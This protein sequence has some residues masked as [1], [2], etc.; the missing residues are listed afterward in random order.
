MSMTVESDSCYFYLVFKVPCNVLTNR[1][2]CHWIDKHSWGESCV[3]FPVACKR[4]ELRVKETSSCLPWVC[5]HLLVD[6]NLVT[7]KRIYFISRVNEKEA[8]KHCG[9]LIGQNEFLASELDIHKMEISRQE[10]LIN[11]QQREITDL[12]EKLENSLEQMEVLWNSTT[13]SLIS[14][15]GEALPTHCV[16]EG[17]GFRRMREKRFA[18]QLRKGG[19]TG[20]KNKTSRTS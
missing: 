17:L 19:R 2:L 15:L 10:D 6:L 5:V 3:K 13:T 9:K 4:I 8:N 12:K 1:R 14:V 11:R 20:L 7:T 18:S 16:F